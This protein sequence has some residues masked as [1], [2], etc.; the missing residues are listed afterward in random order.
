[1]QGKGAHAFENE[2]GG[3]RWQRIPPTEKNGRR[4]TST[5]TVA[6]LREEDITAGQVLNDSELIERFCRSG[7]KGGQ[8]VNKVNTAVTLTHVPTGIS[9][10]VE[11]RHQGKNRQD[12]RERLEEKLTKR[13]KKALKKEEDQKRRDQIGSGMRGD[14]ARTIDEKHDYVVNHTTGKQIRYKAYCKGHVSDLW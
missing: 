1:M 5:V 11:S 10:R 12:A 13:Q 7:G 8:N 2:S 14:K 3:H 4:Q 6:A 9:V